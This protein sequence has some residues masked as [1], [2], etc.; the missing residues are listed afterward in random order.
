MHQAVT[1]VH[2]VYESAHMC[3]RDK[4][5]GALECSRAPYTPHSQRNISNETAELLRVH[6]KRLKSVAPKPIITELPQ[7][8]PHGP[9]K[10]CK[11]KM[12]FPKP[13]VHFQLLQQPSPHQSAVAVR[14]SPQRGH[15]L[16]HK[17]YSSTAHH[18]SK[19]SEGDTKSTTDKRSLVMECA[20]VDD[21]PWRVHKPISRAASMRLRNSI[22]HLRPAP[23]RVGLHNAYQISVPPCTGSPTNLGALKKTPRAA[24]E[25]AEAAH[26]REHMNGKGC[27]PLIQPAPPK[28]RKKVWQYRQYSAHAP[29]GSQPL[30]QQGSTQKRKPPKR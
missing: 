19:S 17:E 10:T 21:K 29:S 18:C 9:T 7:Q 5:E 30:M 1:N 16:S 8:T 6:V 14:S 3:E 28:L 12:A 13:W 22:Q 24:D 15:V 4:H 23:V 20:P 25:S 11:F 27:I 26:A 2:P